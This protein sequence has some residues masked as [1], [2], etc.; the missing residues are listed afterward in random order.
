MKEETKVKAQD[1]AIQSNDQ[2]QIQL[3]ELDDE[4][5]YPRYY[6]DNSYQKEN[7]GIFT[8][9]GRD[10]FGR[11]FFLLG[12][13]ACIFF[14]AK[15]VGEIGRANEEK[16]RRKA[17]EETM[18]G[19]LFALK[20]FNV[21]PPDFTWEKLPIFNQNGPYQ[22]TQ[23]VS[24]YPHQTPA[25]TPTNPYQAHQNQVYQTQTPYYQ[26]YQNY[27]LCPPYYQQYQNYQQ[28][29]VQQTGYTQ[30]VQPNT[31]GY[32]QYQNQYV[33]PNTVAQ[34]TNYYYNN[35]QNTNSQYQAQQQQPAGTWTGYYMSGR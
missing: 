21:V 5:D 17:Q 29:T 28:P 8:E 26:N 27:Y 24:A 32:Y 20:G 11:L 14:G 31:N 1:P 18:R 2:E 6:P 3:E 33:D 9:K 34:N 15:I 10:V 35:Y 12:S 4:M 7:Q 13:A 22:A 19:T 23:K 25:G 16:I 30:Y